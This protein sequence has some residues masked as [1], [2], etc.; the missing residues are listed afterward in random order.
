MRDS[1]SSATAVSSWAEIVEH[2]AGVEHQ[3]D[4]LARQRRIDRAQR[5]KQDHLAEHLQWAQPERQAGFD[6]PARMLSM[7]ARMISVA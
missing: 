2:H 3:Q 1:R 7:P 4:E 6:L 5:R